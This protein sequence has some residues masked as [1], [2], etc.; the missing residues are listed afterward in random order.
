M[1]DLPEAPAPLKERI[2]DA[3]SSTSKTPAAERAQTRLGVALV[4]LLLLVGG[5]A[6]FVYTVYFSGAAAT[7]GIVLNGAILVLFAAGVFKTVVALRH[8]AFEE[9]Q[10]ALF[11]AAQTERDKS[12]FGNLSATSLVVRR[13][14]AIKTLFDRGAPINHG[15]LT[16][17]TM[18][19]ESM[20]LSFPKFVNNVL[21]LTGVFGTVLSL[22]MAMTGASKLVA[23]AAATGGVDQI[24]SGMNTA[25][26]TTATA[27]VLYFVFT[28]FYNKLTDVQT[29]V[30]ARLEEAV[31]LYMIPAFTAEPEAI[32]RQVALMAKRVENVAADLSASLAAV[33]Q[34]ID[35]MEGRDAAHKEEIAD[36]L[37]E[38]KAQRDE[39]K[40][41][42]ALLTEMRELLKDGFRL[43]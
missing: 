31:T 32:G 25:L 5:N 8:Y 42:T 22:I 43:R 37:A 34:M 41:A 2:A 26:T 40:A 27:I 11:N 24:L 33:G 16:A 7:V 36:A 38:V 9:R 21:I 1:N 12:F 13:Y 15:A 30:V 29:H 28:Y 18:A 6:P 14:T 4:L 19:A 10:I 39:A 17:Q 35:A 23:D 20:Y 3:L